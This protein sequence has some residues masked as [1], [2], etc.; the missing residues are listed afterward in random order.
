[1][2]KNNM[3]TEF[4]A[5]PENEAFAR[6][7]AAAFAMSLDP[8][9][10]QLSEIKTAVSEAVTNAVIHGYEKKEGTIIMEGVIYGGAVEYTIRDKGVGISDI[11]R[12]RE[13]LY[14]GK[15]ED[16]RSGMGFT[17][18]ETFMDSLEVESEVGKGTSIVMTKNISNGE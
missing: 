6:S 18:M 12:A 5:I 16:E 10:D 11:R 2:L 3:Y 14:T 13:P 17:I 15:P 9:L 4:S 7:V 1:M 8:T